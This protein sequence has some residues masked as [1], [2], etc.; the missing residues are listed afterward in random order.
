M[1]KYIM[2]FTMICMLALIPIENVCAKT[3]GTEAS[4]KFVYTY[5][6]TITVTYNTVDINQ[7]PATYYYEY[8]NESWQSWMRG[9][10]K[11]TSYKINTKKGTITVTFTGVMR[12]SPT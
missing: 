11:R 8:Y 7:V 1:K 3:I 2:V 9:T 12:S 5:Q 6:E 4:A 10:L